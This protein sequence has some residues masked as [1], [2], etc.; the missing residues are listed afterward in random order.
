MFSQAS[1]YA[2]RALTELARCDP[3]EWVL[4]SQLAKLLDV[5]VHYLAKVLQTLAR[6]GILESQRG[7][8]GGFRLGMSPDDVSA[9]DVVRELDD[10]RSLESCIM[11]EN[12]CS[13]DTAC[14]L[15][16]LWKTIRD[17]FVDALRN[18][19][20]R[21]LADFQEARPGS[22]R[23]AAVKSKLPELRRPG[24]GAAASG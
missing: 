20:L 24:P 2:L 3:Q 17:E 10:I 18:T 16:A 22:G 21:D 19:T 12:D 8:Q 5:P 4:T 15:H 1:E 11:G 9:Y 7:R 13:D 6:R 14:P 23:L